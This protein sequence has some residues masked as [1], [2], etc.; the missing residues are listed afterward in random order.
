MKNFGTALKW[1]LDSHGI[2][3]SE[4]AKTAAIAAIDA[5]YRPVFTFLW[6]T[7]C[8]VGVGWWQ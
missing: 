3:G 6:Q 5:Q 2:G 1:A 4:L 7:G 8:R